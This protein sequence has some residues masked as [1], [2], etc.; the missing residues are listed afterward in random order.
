MKSLAL[1][2]EKLSDWRRWGGVFFK[3]YPCTYRLVAACLVGFD[4]CYEWPKFSHTLCSTADYRHSACVRWAELKALLG[5]LI[6]N[7]PVVQ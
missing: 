1:I 4:F 2:A 6:P 3:V 7:I 5:A